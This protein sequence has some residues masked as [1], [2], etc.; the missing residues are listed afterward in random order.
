MFVNA[1]LNG[2]YLK[3]EEA[4]VSIDDRGFLFGDGVYEVM[5]FYNSVLFKPAEHLAR[6]KNSLDGIELAAP[7]PLEQIEEIASNLVQKSGIKEGVLYMQ[8]TRG[9]A[10]RTHAFPASSHPTVMMKV[11]EVHTETLRESRRGVKV[12]TFPDKRWDY[13]HIKSL[14]LLANVM[15]NEYAQKQGAHEA[16]FL[17]PIGVTECSSSNVF[18]VKE[19]K[20]ITAPEGERILPGITRKLVIQLAREA[21]ISV[22]FRF[23]QNQELFNAD[24]VFI[25]NTVDEVTPVV[26]VDGKAISDGSVGPVTRKLQTM[27]QELVSTTSEGRSKTP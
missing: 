21:E 12:V 4:G 19:G 6:L 25:T 11:S 9:S 24:E 15:A 23:P 26:S 16:V 18:I 2:E 10:P 7:Y 5:R 27:F 14:N 20:I 1:F 3:S 8:I 17:H 13:C 22:E